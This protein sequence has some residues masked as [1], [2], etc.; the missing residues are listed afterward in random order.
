MNSVPIPRLAAALAAITAVALS[1]ALVATGATRAAKPD[2]KLMVPVPTQNAIL[3]QYDLYVI[4]SNVAREIN[5]RGGIRGQ[6]VKMEF[7]NV[8][9]DPNLNEQCARKAASDGV[10]ATIGSLFLFG[11]VS[12]PI[13]EAAHIPAIGAAATNPAELTSPYVFTNAPSPLHTFAEAFLA[14]RHCKNTSL[15]VTSSQYSQFKKYYEAGLKANSRGGFVS[16][17]LVPPTATDMN[18]YVAQA[19][20]GADC[21]AVGPAEPQF[22][23][24][25]GAMRSQGLKQRMYVLAGSSLQPKVVADYA[26]VT[27][28]WYAIS[29]YPSIT[30]PVWKPY[31]DL[32][33]KYHNLGKYAGNIG[34]L[35][36]MRTYLAMKVF[37]QVAT[38]M[39]GTVTNETLYK[40]LT[41]APTCQVDV[42]KMMPKLNYCKEASDPDLRRLFDTSVWIQRIKNGKYTDVSRTFF[43]MLPFYEKG[44]G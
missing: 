24:W 7:C 30:N 17:V 39:K 8:G 19:A 27:N 13:L 12:Q 29:Y 42:G 21:I 32:M 15:V 14:G 31:V 18:A 34:G 9:F 16:A 35:S 44:K 38:K 22:P 6:Q 11:N 10:T 2:I 43:D 33:T 23:A 20:K 41:T 25:L 4:A 5:K 37:E 3:D 1:L 26:D 36:Q 28:G 40:A